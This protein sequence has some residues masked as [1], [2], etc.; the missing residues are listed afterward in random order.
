MNDKGDQVKET[1][2]MS[3]TTEKQNKTLSLSA[4][5][6]DTQMIGYKTKTIK[7]YSQTKNTSFTEK[8][9]EGS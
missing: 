3:E 4:I 5:N 6:D 1:T 9:R 8:L 7:D 2:P